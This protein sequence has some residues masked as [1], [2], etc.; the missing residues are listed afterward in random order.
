MKFNIL[1]KIADISWKAKIEIEEYNIS[2]NTNF[3][4]DN[5]FV[6][7]YYFDDTD[8]ILIAVWNDWFGDID[9]FIDTSKFGSFIESCDTAVDQDN[10]DY[11][12]ESVYQTTYH[13]DINDY[14]SE[15]G[16]E[17]LHY[18]VTQKLRD[19]GIKKIKRPL[20]ERL[21]R[22]WIKLKYQIKLFLQWNL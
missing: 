20:N 10:F 8:E 19:H 17:Q 22:K 15:Y 2:I 18:F 12:T 7:I 14:L 13:M 3:Y 21:K 16:E 6:S 4:F 9:F 11:N 5:D 1:N